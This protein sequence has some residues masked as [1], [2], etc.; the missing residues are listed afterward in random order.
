M[1]IFKVLF[2]G[3]PLS[4][5]LSKSFPCLSDNGKYC[6]RMNENK[7]TLASLKVWSVLVS[8]AAVTA[9]IIIAGIRISD[10]FI[11][12]S[13][14]SATMQT[15]KST[16][17]VVANCQVSNLAVFPPDDAKNPQNAP[18]FQA[19]KYAVLDRNSTKD[20]IYNTAFV[21]TASGSVVGGGAI[22]AGCHCSGNTIE[23]CTSIFQCDFATTGKCISKDVVN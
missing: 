3:R 8:V 16:V 17:L 22:Q 13:K 9:I 2:G 14:L 5:F 11:N 12:K 18:C 19:D 7:K 6:N 20:C 1:N 21:P 4:A 23:T 10:G 15:V